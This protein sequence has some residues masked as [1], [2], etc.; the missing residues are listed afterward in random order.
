MEWISVNE[1]LPEY[2]PAIKKHIEG[3]QFAC[4][5]VLVYNG[6][7]KQTNRFFCDAPRQGLPKT[8]GWR[9]ASDNVSHWMPLPDPPSEKTE[10][11][12]L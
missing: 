3:R 9:W 5:T 7:V 1:R 6:V 2:D 10:K 11:P 8:D 12:P 4:L